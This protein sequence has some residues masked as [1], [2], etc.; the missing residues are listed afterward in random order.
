MQ[1]TCFPTGEGGLVLDQVSIANIGPLFKDHGMNLG[2][3][4]LVA[5]LGTS[6][7]P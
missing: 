2:A 3:L 4:K 5:F 1:M 7:K 6:G